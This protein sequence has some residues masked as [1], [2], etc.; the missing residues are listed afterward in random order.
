MSRIT[1]DIIN[2]LRKSMKASDRK[3]SAYDTQATIRRIEGNTAWVH[4][5]G[6]VD[7]TPVQLTINAKEGD[8]V[9][10]RV[11]GGRAFLVGNATAPPTD[12]SYAKRMSMSL[13]GDLKGTKKTLRG[14]GRVVEMVKDIA[15]N[16]HQYF[17][18]T[19][20]GTDT[21]AHIT[22][23]PQEEFLAD[24][25]HGGGNLLANSN[26]V[27]VRDGREELSVFS[28]EGVRIGRASEGHME[29]TD[30]E[31]KG[32]DERGV[33]FDVVGPVY[34]DTA[35]SESI[36]WGV[37]SYYAV[38]RLQ[39]Y[40]VGRTILLAQ[41]G[42]VVSGA[43]ISVSIRYYNN[44]SDHVGN[45]FTGNFVGGTTSTV[46]NTD[47]FSVTYDKSTEQVFLTSENADVRYAYGT[48]TV[49]ESYPQENKLQFVFG[50]QTPSYEGGDCSISGGIACDAFGDCSFATGYGTLANAR[51]ASAEGYL[52]VASGDFSH[53]EG[54]RS[55]STGDYAHAEG[56]ETIS[57]G[58]A[59]HSEGS[60]NEASG[61]CSHAEGLSTEASGQYAHSEGFNAKST[62]FCSHAEGQWT[63]AS[64]YFSHASGQGTVADGNSQTA[65]GKYNTKDSGNLF[66]VGNGTGN[67]NRSD[68]FTV[69]NSGNARV[70]ET[71]YANDISATVERISLSD[72]ISVSSAN[73]TLIEGSGV[74]FGKTVQIYIKWKTKNAITVPALGNFTNIL[75]GTILLDYLKPILLTAAHSNGDLSGGA[76]W[77]TIHPNGEIYLGACDATGAQRTI[78]ADSEFSIMATYIVN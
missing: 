10:V 21:G 19:E 5:P 77:Y 23:I 75:V 55:Q 73:A 27:A 56:T 9:Q 14:L 50:K 34:A 41:F 61:R 28:A 42:K 22:E 12:D 40:S 37:N 52:T 54:R 49:S 66:S 46:E 76:A 48:T 2:S 36:Q 67:N 7:E 17:W 63:T 4:I 11:S 44:V 78:V 64:G 3:T 18:F 62:G 74:R 43:T 35:S 8:Q 26:G 16:T 65:V 45:T 51:A 24:P 59:S 6:G 68:A 38:N 25:D 72:L 13:S 53:A 47:L 71:L 58:E 32:M 69:D 57:S 30:H 1:N 15:T 31:I 20:E 60:A 29:I 33:H 70:K 39:T